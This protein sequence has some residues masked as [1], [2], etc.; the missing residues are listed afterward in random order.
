[1]THDRDTA[2]L[3]RAA[4]Q[5]LGWSVTASTACAGDVLGTAPLAADG[6]FCG[7]I[8]ER[9]LRRCE[10]GEERIP[11]AVWPILQRALDEY[12]EL[13]R[14][15]YPDKA[16]EARRLARRIEQVQRRGGAP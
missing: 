13:H 3:L 10:R 11:P 9:R 1:M 15:Q 5:R 6:P 7:I 12:I 2:G 16:S 8:T 14:L 4:R